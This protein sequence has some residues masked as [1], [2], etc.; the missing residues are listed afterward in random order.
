MRV[1]KIKLKNFYREKLVDQCEELERKERV[2][3]M[4]KVVS[5]ITREHTEYLSELHE[6]LVNIL[7]DKSSMYSQTTIGLEGTRTRL[8]SREEYLDWNIGIM[9]EK[10]EETF[11]FLGE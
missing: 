10:L 4:N 5:I 2:C 6:T 8:I 7:V 3:L 1:G 9:I 11:P